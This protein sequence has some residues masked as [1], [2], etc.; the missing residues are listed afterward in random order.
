MSDV[1][2]TGT[3]ESLLRTGLRKL[4]HTIA[5]VPV[6]L[7]PKLRTITLSKGKTSLIFHI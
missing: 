7:I 2:F 3:Q 6:D 4:D 5:I 1:K